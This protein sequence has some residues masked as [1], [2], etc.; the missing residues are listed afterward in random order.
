MADSGL[1]EQLR[2]EPDVEAPDLVAVDATDRLLLDEAADLLAAAGP[3][4]VAVVDDSYGALTLGAVAAGARDVR[5]HQDLLVGELALV[6]N[7]ERTGLTGTF[8]SLPLGPGLADGV[9][10][11]LAK[12]PKSLD[13]LREL[14]EVV[15]SSAAPDV[16][17]L[18]GGRVKHMTHAMNDV[19]GLGFTDVH[20]TLARQKSRVLVA[21]GPR[22]G[23]ATSFPRRQHHTDLGLTVCAHGAAFAGTRVD[24]GTRAL[25]AALPRMA[26][27][28]RTALD[29]GSGTGV[30]ATALAL[31]RPGL[32]VLAGD[33]SAAAVASA[34][35]TAAANGVAERVR[36][37]RDDAASTVPDASVDLVVCNP[38][39]HLGAAVV[40]GAADRLFA[41]AGRVLRPGGELW[42]VY[43]NRLPH[44]AALRRLVGPTQVAASDRRFT[45]TVSVKDP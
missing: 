31:A 2:R 38:P 9:G 3:G 26:P 21:R 7:A 4:A 28:A 18:V 11:V 8:R 37:V 42:C 40:T 12:A 19:L 6:R 15:A 45:V 35:A 14:T 5:V 17:L 43:N 30:L 24:A 13:A 33:Q 29:L 1:L 20:A 34:E 44:R 22:E 25:L 23:V 10:L 16:T 41:A 39:F 36:V 32:T 27:D